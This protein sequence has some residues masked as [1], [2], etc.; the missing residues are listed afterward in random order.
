MG[1]SSDFISLLTARGGW[2]YGYELFTDT[3]YFYDEAGNLV[4]EYSYVLVSDQPHKH[5][6]L[7][8]YIRASEIV[9]MW[10]GKGIDSYYLAFDDGEP[11]ACESRPFP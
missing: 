3:D 9:C 11:V 10:I 5:K 4:K 8:H 1:I 7:L 2:Y 6:P